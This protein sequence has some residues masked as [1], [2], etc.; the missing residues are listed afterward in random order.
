[1]RE[2]NCSVAILKPRQPLLDW[3]L[4]LPDGG[5][6]KFTLEEL[7]QDC[8]VLLVPEADDDEPHLRLIRSRCKEIFEAE[9]E[10]WCTD[11]T[12]WPS[13][14][15]FKTF[16][17]WFDIEIHSLVVDMSDSGGDREKGNGEGRL[18]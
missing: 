9:L 18:H 14:R 11:E 6:E 16:R 5:E 15:D 8:T 10:S 2:I 1:M 7:R 13:K 4:Q 3:L 17:A 12:L